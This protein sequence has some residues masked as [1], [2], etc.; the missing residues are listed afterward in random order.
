MTVF[1]DDLDAGSL[2]QRD[3]H[4]RGRGSSRRQRALRCRGTLIFFP[5]D[6]TNAFVTHAIFISCGCAGL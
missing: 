6:Q 4:L 1:P 3:A 2:G 5:A